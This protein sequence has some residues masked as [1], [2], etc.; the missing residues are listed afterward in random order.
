MHPPPPR[1]SIVNAPFNRTA[2]FWLKA[3]SSPDEATQRQT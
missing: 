3:V 2:S 1:M